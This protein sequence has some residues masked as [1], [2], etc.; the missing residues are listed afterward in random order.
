MEYGQAAPPH[1]ALASY[2]SCD[3]SLAAQGQW[4]PILSPADLRS[5]T[6]RCL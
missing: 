4:M 3:P 6:L 5:D 2:G 1:G